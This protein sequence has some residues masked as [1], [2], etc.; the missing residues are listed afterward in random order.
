[1]PHLPNERL[2]DESVTE[3]HGA[4]GGSG[5]LHHLHAGDR[6][7]GIPE[8]PESRVARL[9]QAEAAQNPSATRDP[10]P[11]ATREVV[12]EDD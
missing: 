6:S 8:T 11:M 2:P 12:N 4:R 3:E 10:D 7:H 1:M 9:A 5:L